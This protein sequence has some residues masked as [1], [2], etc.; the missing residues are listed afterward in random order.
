MFPHVQDEPTTA[1]VAQLL[2]QMC[3]LDY[4]VVTFTK[5]DMIMDKCWGAAFEIV[6]VPSLDTYVARYDERHVRKYYDKPRGHFVS[7]LFE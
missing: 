1:G 6:G 3:Y 7:Q 2:A 5:G 4:G